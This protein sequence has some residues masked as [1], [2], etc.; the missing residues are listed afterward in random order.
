MADTLQ[1]EHRVIVVQELN[2]DEGKVIGVYASIESML[3]ALPFVW[4]ANALSDAPWSANAF[5]RD[6][7][8]FAELHEVA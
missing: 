8:L 2:W 7:H 6:R 4:E 1:V 5:P 3:A